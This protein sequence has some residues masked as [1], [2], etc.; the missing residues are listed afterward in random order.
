MLSALAN[1]CRYLY[2][3][4]EGRRETAV[5]QAICLSL[6]PSFKDAADCAYPLPEAAVAA[7]V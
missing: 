7:C 5:F 6:S 1:E 2:M 3:T 4:C